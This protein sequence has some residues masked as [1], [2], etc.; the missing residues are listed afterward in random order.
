[1]SSIPPAPPLPPTRSQQPS[2]RSAFARFVTQPFSRPSQTNRQDSGRSNAVFSQKIPG[3]THWSATSSQHSSLKTR[4]GTV[5]T[6][7]DRNEAKTH[8]VIAGRNIL[9]TIHVKGTSIIEET[10]IRAALVDN[11]RP[12]TAQQLD[13]F[14]VKWSN[15]DFANII[16]AAASNGKVAIYDV[17]KPTEIARLH[18]HTRQVHKVGFSPFAGHLLLSGSQDGTVLLW[19]LRDVRAAVS[20]CSSREKYKGQSDGVRDVQWSPTDM[21]DFAFATDSGVV[22]KWDWRQPSGPKLRINAHDKYCT[23]IDW[24]PD[25][26]HLMSAGHDKTVKVWDFSSESR[27]Q[28]PQWS[29]R[30]PYPVLNA[31]WR[32]EYWSPGDRGGGSWQC[33]QFVTSY[34][35]QSSPVLHLWDFRRPYMPW[36]EICY[37]STAPTDMLWHNQR[38]LWSVG[39]E[40]TF[41]QIDVQYEPKVIDRRP[42]QAFAISPTGEVCVFTQK[43]PRRR[44]SD[45]EFAP[46]S[47]NGEGES[48]DVFS[49]KGELSKSLADDTLDESFLSSSHKLSYGRPMSNRSEKS[50]AS[51][52]P[53]YPD[54]ELRK[55]VELS[56]T[57][58][59]KREQSGPIAQIAYRGFLDG[60]LNSPTFTY[61]AQKYKT[62][63]VPRTPTVNW[64]LSYGM[65]FDQNAKYAER[66]GAYRVAQTWR[67]FN[68]AI[69]HEVQHRAS[70]N[71]QKRLLSDTRS[72]GKTKGKWPKSEEALGFNLYQPTP[73]LK[74]PLRRSSPE[75]SNMALLIGHESS[76]NLPTPLAE[77]HRTL[78]LDSS[79]GSLPNLNQDNIAL[80]QPII[81]GAPTSALNLRDGTS[82]PSSSSSDVLDFQ[83]TQWSQTAKEMNARKAQSQN[84]KAVP[85]QPLEFEMPGPSPGT[86]GPPRFERHNSDESFGM[87]SASSGSQQMGTSMRSY[88]A[89]SH[90]PS[91]SRILESGDLSSPLDSNFFMPAKG[92]HKSESQLTFSKTQSSWLTSSSSMDFGKRDLSGG[93]YTDS[94]GQPGSGVLSA[95]GK[96]REKGLHNSQSTD[97]QTQESYI[98]S[99]FTGKGQ[100]SPLDPMSVQAML[101]ELYAYYSDKNPNVQILYILAV[102]L[103]PY[104]TSLEGV[105][106]V[107][108]LEHDNALFRSTYGLNRSQHEAVLSSY[109]DQLL[110]L[111]ILPPSVELARK[112]YADHEHLFNTENSQIAFICLSCSKPLNNPVSKFHCETCGKRQNPCP[113]CWQKYPAFEGTKKTRKQALKASLFAREYKLSGST[114]HTRSGQVAISPEL[115]QTQTTPS[116]ATKAAFVADEP[117][118]TSVESIEPQPAQ[119][120][121]PILWQACLVCGHGAHAACLQHIQND[122]AIGGTCPTEGCLCDCIPGPYRTQLNREAELARL[123]TGHGL[124]RGDSRS[125]PESKAVRGVKHLLGEER[126]VR[127][128][129]PSITMKR[130]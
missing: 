21:L 4:S 73:I 35:R 34:D 112:A 10:N 83:D 106:S 50:A 115:Q 95:N 101:K 48:G 7:L 30:T 60:T 58:S 84:W 79:T 116:T 64:Y 130:S 40:G 27:R 69:Q 93:G 25:G 111:Q 86:T 28:K 53:S 57:L 120:N 46:P 71:R 5:I 61:L 51:T 18:E 15:K 12:S 24:H 75:G 103:Q 16:A 55:V 89:R 41:Q 96:N 29:I 92:L 9:Q 107:E 90:R 66:T 124:V 114:S 126:R 2:A 88:S 104:I 87:L 59:K 81:R 109:H 23:A 13:I 67:L 100:S 122:P 3:A 127:L 82:H 45:V 108:S 56:V 31:R 102:A 121:H 125:I 65:V 42:M 110:S 8:A 123:K 17:E 68:A 11:E 129:E 72:N 20:K 91:M 26:K 74:N 22:Q 105:S 119:S 80:P 63:S 98:L 37:W 33:T 32:P 97:N 19:D 39:R 94:A 99:D 78:Q 113:I 1:M 128:V 36:R 85:R 70:R 62:V 54:G 14:D 52:P 118:F 117:L 47:F 38:L 76:S 43:R 49:D 77:P 6:A 44:A